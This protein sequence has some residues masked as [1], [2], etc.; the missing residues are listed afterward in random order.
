MEHLLKVHLLGTFATNWKISSKNCKASSENW[1]PF[2]VKIQGLLQLGL[3]LYKL[4]ISEK[5]FHT[6]T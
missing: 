1:K 4:Y 6:F 2:F 5:V 3:G